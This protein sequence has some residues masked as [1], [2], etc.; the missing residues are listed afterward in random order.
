MGATQVSPGVVIFT[1]QPDVLAGFYAAV[2]AP[3]TIETVGDDVL[4]RAV[5]E[6]YLHH[7]SL[8][9]ERHGQVRS[10]AAVK[11]QFT[12]DDL[13][14]ARTA[15]VAS[16]GMLTNRS[17]T[18]NA[19]AHLDVVDPDGNVVQLRCHEEGSAGAPT[20]GVVHRELPHGSG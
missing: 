18:W 8:A 9:S 7:A 15:V 10:D 20:R 16:G 4:V 11:P 3:S 5:V 17:F 1:A 6:A 13:E 2:L 14:R 19:V 12:V